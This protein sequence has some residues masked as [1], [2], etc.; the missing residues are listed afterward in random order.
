MNAQP[1]KIRVTQNAD[2]DET[3]I[4]QYIEQK[5]GKVFA[6]KFRST[7]IDLFNKLAVMPTV[8]RVAKDDHSIRVFIFSHQKKSS[9]KS[10]KQ[11]S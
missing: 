1:L 5:F 4:Y 3:S 9:I 2:A 7:L 8:G 6:Q 10:R 11:T